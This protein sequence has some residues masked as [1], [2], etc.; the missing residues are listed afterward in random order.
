GRI[1]HVSDTERALE[2]EHVVLLEHIAHQTAALAAVELILAGS[3][4]TRRILPAVL[5]HCHR[6]VEALIDRSRT[7]NSDN[8]AHACQLRLSV[9]K[10]SARRPGCANRWRFSLPAASIP[11]CATTARH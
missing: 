3:G 7:D 6:I 10:T 2:L 8:S 9:W 5:Q 4:D 1:A 11:T